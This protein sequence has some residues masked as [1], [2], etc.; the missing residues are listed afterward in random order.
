MMIISMVRAHG[1]LI[2]VGGIRASRHFIFA[3]DV[4]FQLLADLSGVQTRP[5]TLEED[6][7]RT[8]SWTAGGQ[9]FSMSLLA[10]KFEKGIAD[11]RRAETALTSDML[12]NGL[13][14]G[15]L[16][17]TADRVGVVAAKAGLSTA[18]LTAHAHETDLA[19]LVAA[20]TVGLRESAGL[21]LRHGDKESIRNEISILHLYQFAIS[22]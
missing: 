18:M 4:V 22:E 11:L 1:C 13:T 3:L 7:S 5:D 2:R 20:D 19:G 12:E 8:I 10:L 16:G 6:L 17:E 15:S 21:H 14:C 9:A